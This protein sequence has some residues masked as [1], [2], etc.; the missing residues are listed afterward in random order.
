MDLS[1]L[2]PRQRARFELEA[3]EQQRL[4]DEAKAALSGLSFG[5]R[6]K[7]DELMAHHTSFRVGG[8][9]E[10]LIAAQDVQDVR[11][12][13]IFAAEKNVPLTFLGSGTST[14]VRDGGVRGIVLELGEMFGGI[15]VLREEGDAK[16]VAVG[17]GVTVGEIVRW[18]TAQRLQ[19]FDAAVDARGTVAGRFMVAPSLFASC[20]EELTIIDKAGRE[21]TLTRKAITDGERIRFGRSAAITKM[22]L[23]LTRRNDEAVSEEHDKAPVNERARLAG[24]FKNVGKQAA[25]GIVADA[26]LSGIRVGRVRVN[27][28]DANSFINEGNAKA[29]DALVLIGLIKERVKQSSGVMLDLAVRV[30]GEE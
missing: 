4:T 23:K 27:S 20:I 5:E 25:A 15:E 6:V 30:I 12:V 26:G 10:A 7:P 21:M 29:R 8:T 3:E 2:S 1:A 16:F 14:L 11:E 24:V 9:A 28:E 22:V 13:I 19:G 17:A 18:S